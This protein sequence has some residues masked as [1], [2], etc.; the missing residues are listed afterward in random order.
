MTYKNKIYII[1]EIGVN[2]NGKEKIALK[3]ID[4]AKKSGADV[5][6]FQLF[7][8]ENLITKIAKKPKYIESNK[9]LKKKSQ[10]QILKDLELS[11]ESFQKLKS[12]CNKIKIEFLLSPFDLVSIEEIKK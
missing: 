9:I 8:A 4:E 10:Y 11:L 3:L 1:A 6:K 7:K 12:Y 5:V 2:H